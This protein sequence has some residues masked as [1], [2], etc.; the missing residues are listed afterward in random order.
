MNKGILRVVR[1]KPYRAGMGPTFR[2]TTWDTRRTGYGK[3]IIGYRLELRRNG[4]PDSEK[5]GRAYTTLFEGEDFGCSPMYGID[6]DE[7]IDG[8]MTF[9]T[10]RPGDTD[11]EYFANY[12]PEQL[13]YCSKH[14]EVLASEVER[15]FGR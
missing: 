11:P 14:A 5:P 6:S 1:F 15:R 13:D 10:L 7:A 12:T 9:L 8:I 2:L 4:L 3:S